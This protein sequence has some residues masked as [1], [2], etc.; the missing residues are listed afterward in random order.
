MGISLLRR[1]LASLATAVRLLARVI[2]ILRTPGAN[3]RQLR[4]WNTDGHARRLLVR[5]LVCLS[6]LP[7]RVTDAVCLAG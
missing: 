7:G 4:A 5:V 1:P 3:V 6:S 2:A